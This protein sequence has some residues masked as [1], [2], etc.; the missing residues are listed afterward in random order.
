M[1]DLN[2][3]MFGLDFFRLADEPQEF[4]LHRRNESR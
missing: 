1:S 3:V 2:Q 4:E